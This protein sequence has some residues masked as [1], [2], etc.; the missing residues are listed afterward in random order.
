MNTSLIPAPNQGLSPDIGGDFQPSLID[1]AEA[2][3][4]WLRD[5]CTIYRHAE[6]QRVNLGV[7]GSEGECQGVI[8]TLHN[9]GVTRDG[10]E[11]YPMEWIAGD[12]V[13]VNVSRDTLICALTERNITR[14]AGSEFSRQFRGNPVGYR[15]A[16][17]ELAS[18]W[19]D[20]LPAMRLRIGR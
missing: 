2:A 4:D 6:G 16:C 12:M 11:G 19:L 9:L 8:D 5:N 18:R 10:G 14:F 17:S 3:P 7:R 15:A 1:C 20:N 13:L